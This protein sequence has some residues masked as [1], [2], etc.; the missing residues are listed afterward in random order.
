MRYSGNSSN[1]VK[2]D[3]SGLAS[4]TYLARVII[5]DSVKMVKIIKE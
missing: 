4:A 2:L 5:G 1:S 3:L